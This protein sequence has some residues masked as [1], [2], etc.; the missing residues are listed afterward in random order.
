MAAA[1]PGFQVLAV[2]SGNICRSPLV[3]LLLREQLNRLGGRTDI[4]T[5]SAGT[6]ARAGWQ[7]PDEGKNTARA[8]GLGAA[9]LDA[10]RAQWLR[11]PTVGAAGLVL[12]LTRE[13]RAA[14]VELFPK[15]NRR[16]FTLAQLARILPL[17]SDDEIAASTPAQLVEA[18]HLRRN[19]AV[20]Q[21]REDD[22]IEDPF[23][24]GQ[25]V[26]DRVGARIAGSVDV[27]ASALS[28]TLPVPADDDVEAPK[29][30]RRAFGFP[31]FKEWSS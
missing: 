18:A 20:P 17:L 5:A 30:G 2:C 7:M 28:R 26:Y 23:G 19:D 8:L 10:H 9:E 16:A 24:R 4:T 11:E 12:G 25:D 14:A 29:P 6:I 1:V 22:D 3:E 27:I 31:S 13:H 21:N 15:A